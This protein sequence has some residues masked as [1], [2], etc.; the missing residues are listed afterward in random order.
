MD[1]IERTKEKC[2]D[3]RGVNRIH[4][5]V[6][7][8]RFGLR[9]LRK[10]PSFTAVAIL[11]LALGIGANTSIF[12]IL[13]AVMM[14]QLPV[15]HPEQLVLFHWIAHS[16]GPYVWSH[17]SSYGDCDMLNPAS[18][19]SNCSFSFP[20]YDNFRM[21]ARSFEGIACACRCIGTGKPGA[22]TLNT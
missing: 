16:R 21:H 20:D 2:R 13:N 12:T 10:S 14:A 5:F 17:T 15:G 6:Q 11:T 22:R 4:D 19:D 3:A 18:H 7:Y 8:L 9:M 1:G